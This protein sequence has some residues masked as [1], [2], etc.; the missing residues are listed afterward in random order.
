MNT[1]RLKNKKILLLF[2]SIDGGT[3]TY[4]DGILTLNEYF[5]NAKKII[6]VLVLDKPKFRDVNSDGILY[7]PRKKSMGVRY[8]INPYLVDTF[9]KEILWFKKCIQTFFPDIVISS[10]S[11]SILISEIVKFIFR[12]KYK[13]INVIHNN[14]RQVID[15]RLNKGLKHIFKW[16]FCLFLKK[17]NRVVTV[18]RKLSLDVY[19][20]YG[21]QHLPITIPPIF[22][23]KDIPK[24][25]KHR[26]IGKT[27]ISVARLDKQK[28]HITL[29]KAFK[30]AKEKL[31][32]L[33]L[34]IIG[35]GPL[36]LRLM[37][38]SKKLGLST[39][40]TFTG[41]KQNPNMDLYKSDVFIHSSNWEGFGLSI[42]EAMRVGL[43]VIAS[44]CDYGPHEIIG[45][46]KYG[47]LVPV[48]DSRI[49]ANAIINIFSN[50]TLYRH[51]SQMAIKRSLDYST[52]KIIK[53]YKTLI[54]SV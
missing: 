47:I 37:S 35:D 15:M 26:R 25:N 41:W 19:K 17:S 53:R 48:K 34:K 9:I 39:S 54:D 22:Q 2:K 8:R 27:L 11:H 38:L 5:P 44:D 28:D 33:R 32:H 6:K 12:T 50:K 18:S 4:M 45:N 49:M 10:D 13:T 16:I 3:G 30:L 21:L 46:N 42:I 7:F 52:I 29:L 23:Y 40:V 36:R 20:D 31:P 51:M 1:N 14:L 24:R 43:P